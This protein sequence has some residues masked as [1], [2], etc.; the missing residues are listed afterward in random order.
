MH[1][2]L[3]YVGEYSATIYFDFKEELLIFIRG[4][5]RL[6]HAKEYGRRL[7]R[8]TCTDYSSVL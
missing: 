3:S 8:V 6:N 2:F 7:Q 5:P 1:L 4:C